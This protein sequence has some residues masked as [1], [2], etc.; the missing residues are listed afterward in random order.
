MEG[1]FWQT[2]QQQRKREEADLEALRQRQRPR[3]CREEEEAAME[4][5]R[6]RERKQTATQDGRATEDLASDG[7]WVWQ[8]LRANFRVVCNKDRQYCEWV[9]WQESLNWAL[10]EF[11]EFVRVAEGR[12]K[13]KEL[14]MRERENF[15]GESTEEAIGGKCLKK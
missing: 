11:Q 15:G 5:E 12:E 8:I 1:W 6:E 3:R 4:R 7:R 13:R 10:L 2:R 14:E 9:S